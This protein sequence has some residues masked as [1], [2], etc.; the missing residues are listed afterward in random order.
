MAGLSALSLEPAR[1]T[2]MIDRSSY[3]VSVGEHGAWLAGQIGARLQ[4]RHVREA[5]E[6][7]EAAKALLSE[8]GDRLVDQGAPT[9]DLS[10]VEGEI[11]DA[12]I[13]ASA[14]LLVLGKR[15]EGSGESR[16]LLGQHVEAVLRGLEIPVCLA[17]KVFLPIHRVVVLTD[18]DIHHRVALDLLAAGHG[19]DGLELDAVIV[20]K[21]GEDPAA[22]LTLARQILDGRAAAFAIHAEDL[23]EAVWRY[24][25]DRPAD[26]IVVSRAVLLGAG[27]ASLVVSADSLWAARASVLVC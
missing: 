20:A 3:T 16:V 27:A 21:P 17:A 7:V 11:L 13:S 25:E 14:E 5:G 24:L 10:L 18:A 6:T 8:A 9:P 22:K 12:A 19:L 1:V 23:G 4:L 2:A 26:L 15:G